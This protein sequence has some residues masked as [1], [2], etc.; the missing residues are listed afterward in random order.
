M[1]KIKPEMDHDLLE[2][3]LDR[4]EDIEQKIR[5]IIVVLIAFGVL[6]LIR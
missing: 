4:F 6:F 2:Y 3:F 1:A 5:W